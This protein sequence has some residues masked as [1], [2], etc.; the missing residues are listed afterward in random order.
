MTPS[1]FGCLDT[2][3]TTSLRVTTSSSTL[4]PSP[5]TSPTF[6]LIYI[7]SRDICFCACPE[8]WLCTDGTI[9]PRSWFIKGLHHFFYKLNRRTVHACRRCNFTSGEWCYPQPHPGSQLMDFRNLQ[10]LCV[11]TPLP[12]Q[13]SPDWPL[14]ASLRLNLV[15]F[16]FFPFS[17][18]FIH[19]E[20]LLSD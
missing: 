9:P 17:L 1:D 13:S 3:L 2:K 16:S 12:F 20:L 10:P 11:E 14:I 8:L 7:A 6:T 5:T 18:L 15:L 4:A 19:I